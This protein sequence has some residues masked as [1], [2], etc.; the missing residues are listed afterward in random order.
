MASPRFAPAGL[1]VEFGRRR[2]MLDGGEAAAPHGSI[3]AWLVTDEQAELMPAIRRAART[4]GVIPKVA[5]YRCAGLVCRP[6]PVVH[7]SHPTY[8]YLLETSAGTAA[9]APEFLRFPS[10]AEGVDLLFAEAAGWNRPIRFRGGVGGHAAALD[11]ARD[12]QQA[13]V[14]RLVF[15]HLGRP[16]L[17]AIDAG[18]RPPFGEFGLEGDVFYLSPSGRIQR[19]RAVSV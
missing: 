2:L 10:W 5:S 6:L 19:K 18:L 14:R 12:A 3:A 7:T 13:H 17:R 16:T 4:A 8:G 9:W 15:A 1:L 11:V